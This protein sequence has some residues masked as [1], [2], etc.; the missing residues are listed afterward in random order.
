M[1]DLFV[2]ELL[3]P[4]EEAVAGVADDDMDP[5]EVVAL[6]RRKKLVSKLCC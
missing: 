3:R 1:D 2:A 5:A 6:H 4:P